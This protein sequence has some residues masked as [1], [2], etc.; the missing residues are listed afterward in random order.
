[1]LSLSLFFLFLSIVSACRINRLA[2]TAP[3]SD[4]EFDR[5]PANNSDVLEFDDWKVTGDLRTVE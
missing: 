3:Q 4:G 5:D 1:M 2:K